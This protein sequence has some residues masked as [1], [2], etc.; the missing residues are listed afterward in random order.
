MEAASDLHLPVKQKRLQSSSEGITLTEQYGS[1]F[2]YLRFLFVVA[3]PTD[4]F[5]LATLD[6]HETAQII[7]GCVSVAFGVVIP[8]KHER[9]L[10]MAKRQWQLRRLQ[11]GRTA[12]EIARN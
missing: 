6:G 12:T 3:D 11:S 10:R 8:L 2:N 9:D 1:I 7:T 4:Q 5:N